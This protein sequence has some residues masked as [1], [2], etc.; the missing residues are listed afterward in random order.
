MQND[1]HL[2]WYQVGVMISGASEIWNK[3]TVYLN[4]CCPVVFRSDGM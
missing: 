3:N 2:C 4:G 1:Y